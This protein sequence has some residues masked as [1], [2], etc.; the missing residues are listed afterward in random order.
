[1]VPQ[2]LQTIAAALTVSLLQFTSAAASPVSASAALTH[3]QET[4]TNTTA[5]NTSVPA[6][7]AVPWSLVHSYAGSSF[8]DGWDFFNKTDPTGGLVAYQNRSAAESKGLAYVN[9]NGQAVIK[10][11]SDTDL[12]LGTNRSSVRI[13]SQKHYYDGMVVWDIEKTPY[14]CAVWASCWMNTRSNGN[15]AGGEFDVIEQVGDSPTNAATLHTNP[16]C[17][18]S[19]STP[20]HPFSGGLTR[21]SCATADGGC[22]I[23]DGNSTFPE[24]GSAFNNQSGGVYV[25]RFDSTGFY[26]WVFPRDRVPLDITSGTPQ[27]DTWDQVPA[28]YFSTESCE[29]SEYFSGNQKLII[30]ITLGGE[31]AGEGYGERTQ[32]GCPGTLDERVMTGKNFETAQWVFNSIKVYRQK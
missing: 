32:A 8:F 24:Y 12:P 1:M 7:S 3:V 2:Y 20:E 23:I 28:A 9:S 17:T 5:T 30:N 10:V 18:T 21:T 27:P 31:W 6:S 4:L 16:G 13:E 11:D 14:G 25:S 29:Y 26:V 19:N 15:T 22:G